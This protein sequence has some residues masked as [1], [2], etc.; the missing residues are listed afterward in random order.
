MM[1]RHLDPESPAAIFQPGP[2]ECIAVVPAALK[3]EVAAWHGNAE[4]PDA[5]VDAEELV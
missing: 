1:T 3:D 5:E 4:P 2:G